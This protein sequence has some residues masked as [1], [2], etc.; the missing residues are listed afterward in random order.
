MG[1]VT[2]KDI[3][4]LRTRLTTARTETARREE[5]LEAAKRDLERCR[6]RLKEALDGAEVDQ[7]EKIIGE[8]RPAKTSP[9]RPSQRIA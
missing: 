1:T 2:A 9:R 7:A 4:G 6:G 3:E 8:R 5:R